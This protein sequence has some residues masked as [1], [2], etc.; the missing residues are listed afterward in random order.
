MTILYRMVV[1][2]DELMCLD[3]LLWLGD[4]VC[5]AEK[6]SVSQ[7]TLSRNAR[8]AAAKLFLGLTKR[9]LHWYLTGDLSFLQAERQL[10]QRIRW[11][12]ALPLRVDAQ[13]YSGPLFADG[14]QAGGFLLGN[15]DLLDVRKPLSL[16]R[17]A[18]LDVWIAGYPD[19]PDED[20]EAFVCH[21]LTRLPL[22]LAVAVGHPLL[23]AASDLSL[24]DIVSYPSMAL[25]EGAFP[26]SEAALKA[27]GLWN[28][29]MR[30]RRY[31][32]RKWLGQTQDQVTVA[33]ASSFSIG[34][35]PQPMEFLPIDL[36]IEVG[37]VVV[38]R[39]EFS[40]HPRFLDL[41]KRLQQRSLE[42]ACQ[43]PDIALAF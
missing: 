14:L 10:H 29:P 38:V 26:R 20:D 31:D 33:Y 28:S 27:L 37:E 24:E 39:R 1:S 40:E 11:N 8:A 4:G 30:M 18:I 2:I 21:R 43:F 41:L 19:V 25:P 16:L 22:R 7:S 13:F 6:I 35:F 34:L 9:D 3:S 36:G 42:V 15:L 12:K 32:P 5:A 23:Q 17:D